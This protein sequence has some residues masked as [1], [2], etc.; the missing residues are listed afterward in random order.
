MTQLNN[1]FELSCDTKYQSSTQDKKN[2][3]NK[4]RIEYLNGYSNIFSPRSVMQL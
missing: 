4:S 1:L 3:K 2:K